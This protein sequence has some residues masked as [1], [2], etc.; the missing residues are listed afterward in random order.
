MR[1]VWWVDMAKLQLLSILEKHERDGAHVA[2]RGGVDFAV[3]AA[4]VGWQ[5]SS[6][7]SK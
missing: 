5:P 3:A 1:S 4:T 7:R 6:R 2:D